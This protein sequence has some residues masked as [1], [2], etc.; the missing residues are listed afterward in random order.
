MT[1]IQRAA[2][3]AATGLLVLFSAGAGATEGGG[4]TYS[5]GVEN[6]LA[7]AVPPPGLY[8]LEYVLDYHADKLE[9]DGGHAIPI[10]GFEISAQVAATRLVWST[11]KPVLGGT[12]VVHGIFPLVSLRV[13]VPGVGQR[14]TGLGDITAGMGVAWHHSPQ[15]H[16]V[17]D[18]DVVLPTGQYD[19]K[20]VA[21]I[22]RNY[23]SLQPLYAL[24][25]IDP[26]GL[27]GDFK[28]TLNFNQR[29]S[30]TDYKS[31][32]EFILD[33]SAGWGLGNG[34]VLGAGGY[35]YRQLTNDE[36]S[37]SAVP[38]AKARAYALGPAIKYDNGKG[39]FITAKWQREMAVHDR[40]EGSAFWIKTLI[41]F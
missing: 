21:N 26:N 11:D 40:P 34:W 19:K 2:R 14:M 28:A 6:F 1:S 36:V 9:D 5:P 31:G 25:Y 24:S 15:W 17:A 18:L 41:P 4:S 10:P 38:N 33:Y 8:V 7:G 20:D 29:N 22:G 3:G 13:D 27:N 35:G 37:G 12:L 16:S 30:A 39:W 32:T 23:A